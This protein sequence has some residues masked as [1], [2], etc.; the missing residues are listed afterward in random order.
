MKIILMQAALLLVA[1][2]SK[3]DMVVNIIA[4]QYGEANRGHPSIA[5]HLDAG[6]YRFELANPSTHSDATQWAWQPWSGSG[7]CTA[8]IIYDGTTR[9]I[10]GGHEFAATPSEAFSTAV[11]NGSSFATVFYETAR[12]VYIGVSDSEIRDNNG[13]SSLLITSVPEPA[14]AA[15]F[16]F[17]SA[18]GYFIRKRFV[19]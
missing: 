2:P 10:V 7:W 9:T 6:A 4:N 15:S 17:V 19:I 5:V 14:G 12:T 11:N 1:M 3:G 16:V 8:S 13:G 18:A